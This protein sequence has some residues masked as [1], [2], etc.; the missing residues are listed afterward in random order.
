MDRIWASAASREFCMK[1]LPLVWAGLWRRPVRTILTGLCIAIAFLLLGLLDGVNAGFAKAIADAHRDLL[2]TNTR[3]RG[4]GQMPIS[5]M[6]T[7][8]NIPGVKDVAPRAY[9]MGSYRDPAAKNMVGAI[10]TQ[11]EL[12]FG[13]R[14]FFSVTR[15]NLD[16]MRETRAGL[17]AT[18]ALLND[19]GWK[20]GDT[21][22]LHSQTLK[23]DGSRDWAF[24]IV[25]T[26]DSIKDPGRASFGIINYAYLDEYRVENR[27]TAETFYVRIAD[28]TKAIATA[29]AIDQ[30]FANSS[31]ETRTRSDQERAEYQAKQMG[32]VEFFTNSIMGAV[33][34]TLAFLTGNTLR[35]SLHE[36]I[37]EFAVLK[38][39]GYSNGRVFSLGVAE[40]LLL[41]LPPAVLG[42]VLAYLL[43]PLAKEN[44]GAIVVSPAVATAGMLCAGLLAVIG[45]AL[46]ARRLARMSV[47][48]ALGKR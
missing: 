33:L 22:T 41:Y 35:Q 48:A 23:T 27:G 8:Q 45:A 44:I 17:L 38:A 30:I 25:G 20:V 37:P 4:G 18:P 26:F 32:D 16:A 42:L 28:P 47:A 6:T 29:A 14:P 1:F 3:V 12:F 15:E 34:F 19:F 40:A 39:L 11:P 43:A 13:L 9:L 31:H 10:A 24:H 5:A 21:V 36:R 2:V 7:I 46:P